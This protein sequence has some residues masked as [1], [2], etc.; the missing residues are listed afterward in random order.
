[1][2]FSSGFYKGKYF[3][4]QKADEIIAG[5]VKLLHQVGIKVP[6]D[7]LLKKIKDEGFITRNNRVYIEPRM[8]YYYLENQR[9]RL[10]AS[11]FPERRN[12]FDGMVCI[13]SS[14]LESFENMGTIEPFTTESL[15]RAAKFVEKCSVKYGFTP[16]V[17]GYATDVPPQLES[18]HKYMISAKYCHAGL[19]AEPSSIVSA[20]YMFEMAE[21][22]GEPIERLPIFP[23]SPLNLSGESVE[24]VLAFKDRIKSAYVY[25]MS[26]WG[27]TTPMSLSMGFA[28]NLAEVIG[29]AIIM[30]TLLNIPVDIKPNLLPFDL[31]SFSINFGSA[32]K[33][34][35]EL[36]SADLSAQIL[37][38]PLDYS[39][40]NIHTIAQRANMQS[41]SE[42]AGLIYAGALLGAT[43]FYTIGSLG[44]DEIFSPYQLLLDLEAMKNAEKIVNGISMDNIPDDFVQ[45]VLQYIDSGF[46]MSDRTL[47]NFDSFIGKTDIYSRENNLESKQVE[48]RICELVAKIDREDTSYVLDETRSREL[49]IIYHRALENL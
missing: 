34:I 30:E 44:L 17:P 6:N 33:F 13:Y 41:A 12:K 23:A 47:D 11:G 27:V 49:D 16:N 4:K 3:S 9:K 31:R 46:T 45:E 39:S 7:S 20:K 19:P 25:C 2:S 22:M 40:T 18:L 10:S 15:I 48:E 1:M 26:L 37:D 43:K 21:V 38:M 14:K 42:K 5:A 35:L 24:T 32:E 8:I 36:M 28:M 29:V